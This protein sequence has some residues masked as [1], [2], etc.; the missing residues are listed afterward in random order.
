MQKND[1][2]LVLGAR[3]M[4]GSAIAR[5]LKHHH[6]ERVL[7]PFRKELDLSSQAEVCDYFEEHKPEHVFMCAAKV[8]GIFAN[9]EYRADFILQNTIMQSNVFDAALKTDVRQFLFMGSSCIYP[10]FAEQPIK[11]ESLLTGPLEPTNE[12][13]AI[14]KIS[15]LKTAESIRRQY[16]KN[17]FSVMPTNLYGQGDNYHPMNSHVIP[18]L[19]QRMHQTILS[20]SKTFEVWGT[21][22]PKREFLYVDD[23]AAACLFLMQKASG[24][25]IGQE[26]PDWINIGYGDDIAIKDLAKLI[27]DEMGF[28][29]EIVFNTKYPDGTPRKLL[30]SSKIR[31]LGW[32]PKWD[33]KK[34]LK[35]AI[36]GFHEFQKQEGIS[37]VEV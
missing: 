29:G 16:G 8:G 20:G 3:G 18:G 27:A 34:G 6:F 10:K 19:I 5:V 2:I 22:T 35:E 13:Y 7:T 17:F 15:G 24:Q 37:N 4:V 28:R 23:L 12:P 9:N 26:I 21:G 25:K 36:I 11:E 32:S 31:N 1:R 14:A 33:L 30:D